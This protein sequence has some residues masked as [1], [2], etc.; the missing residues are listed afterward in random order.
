MN[1]PI[2]RDAETMYVK[3]DEGHVRDRVNG[4]VL[5]VDG[6]DG[7]VNVPLL[8]TEEIA[9]SLPAGTNKAI[10]TALDIENNA[11]ILFVF[12]SNDDHGIYRYSKDG[13]TVTI[14][15]E[16]QSILG[17]LSTSI[18]DARVIGGFLVWTDN[19]EDP[20]SVNIQRAINF[21]SA[22]VV[23]WDETY[24]VI[25]EDSLRFAV[26]S[27]LGVPSITSSSDPSRKYNNLLGKTFQ[28]STQ[29]VYKDYEYSV[30]S[31]YSEV[32]VSPSLVSNP[33]STYIDDTLGNNVIVDFDTGSDEVREIRLLAREGNSG[34]WFI[35]D[36][37]K[38]NGTEDPFSSKT[39]SFYDD[40]SREVLSRDESLLLFYSVPRLAK[41]LE[42]AKN[43]VVLSNLLVGY[44]RTDVDYTLTLG[45]ETVSVGSGTTPIASTNVGSVPDYDIDFAIPDGFSVGDT[46]AIDYDF[47]PYSIEK[48][49]TEFLFIM[50][51][52]SFLDTYVV[53]SG[54]TKTD[55][56]NAFISK[57]N[58]QA[59]THFSDVDSN[60]PGYFASASP[61]LLDLGGTDLRL[62]IRYNNALPETGFFEGDI[63]FSS[64]SNV[65]SASTGSN[66]FKSLTS[67]NIGIQYSDNTGQTSGVL[68]GVDAVKYIPG[69]NEREVADEGKSVFMTWV[70]SGTPPPWATKY[71]FVVSEAIGLSSVF[72][73]HSPTVIHSTIIDGRAMFAIDFLGKT[74]YVF[75]DGDLMV[76]DNGS[77]TDV[78]SILGEQ[79]L[80]TDTSAA[81][82][83]GRFILIAQDTTPVAELQDIAYS[84]HRAK[85]DVEEVV[86][87]EDFNSYNVVAGEHETT[88]GE[89]RCGDAWIIN[90]RFQFDD[91]GIQTR[92]DLVE[93][94]V[95]NTELNIR[96]Y[97][98]GR[99]SVVLADFGEK[100][101][102][103]AR[104]G[105]QFF[106]DTKI[107]ELQAFLP[108]SSV[109]LEEAYGEVN[110]MTLVGDVLKFIQE[111]K[112]TSIYV[113][114]A[115]TTDADGN[116]VLVSIDGFL[117][118]KNVLLEDYGTKYKTSVVVNDRNL[119]YWDGE[120]GAVIRSSPNQQFPISSYGM[121]SFFLQ[122]KRDIDIALDASQTVSVLFGFDDRN[123]ELLVTFNINDV[124]ETWAFSEDLKGWVGRYQ[125]DLNSK[126]PDIYANIGELLY[127]FIDGSLFEHNV[128]TA[129]NTIYGVNKPFSL[130]GLLN[131]SPINEKELKSIVMDSDNTF[132]VL[133]E[134]PIASTRSFAYKTRIN[135]ATWR[136]RE[137]KYYSPV[138]RNI[139]TN[140]GEDT[141]LYYVGDR[142]V[143]RYALLTFSKT[144]TDKFE[145]RDLTIEYL[146]VG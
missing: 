40:R 123:N 25:D 113:D 70:L 39:V 66:T 62:K 90:R 23:D 135:E 111:N 125:F 75:A 36:I 108:L 61:S 57:F 102:Q 134:T 18:I 54:D 117:G 97:S 122:K 119:Y 101:I 121:T 129:R 136:S 107:N 53:Q 12:N 47:T 63:T 86:Y 13:G 9:L 105:G 44:D 43:R 42:I 45:Y 91:S 128:N 46:I 35:A 99:P 144:T 84:I 100:R 92:D 77:E 69:I 133:I 131:V 22:A 85:K 80:I 55:I 110:G 98:Q 34:D 89:L 120:R 50:W 93:D 116:I 4:R 20:R 137:G 81:E 30:L 52:A 124:I 28:F 2:D 88:T 14:I 126:S 56:I 11:I 114:K 71:K 96:S 83:S 145:L 115:T 3:T 76:Y 59:G 72:P 65:T 51:N 68:L 95:I 74:S 87:F 146:I 16:N 82:H 6:E 138:L 8:G 118:N 73:S 7:L 67:Y 130:Q 29:Y 109:S 104:W 49:L 58:S 1:G 94:F 5:S 17:F 79:L 142:M 24:Q 127:S 112:E 64:R 38:K 31:P 106:R 15:L 132:D 60:Y 143:G 21:T 48:D 27:P 139:N 103:D 26:S 140:S 19:V 10:G 33:D 37:Y 32:V 78:K 41:N 141:S